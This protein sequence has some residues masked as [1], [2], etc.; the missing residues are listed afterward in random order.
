MRSHILNAVFRKSGACANSLLLFGAVLALL[1][2]AC[3]RRGRSITQ[4]KEGVLI[5]STGSFPLNENRL[6]LNVAV[7][8]EGIVR[9]ALKDR[10]GTTLIDSKKRTENPGAYQRWFLFWSNDSQLWF[11]SSDIGDFLWTKGTDGSYGCRWG[12]EDPKI[13][14]EMPQPFFDALPSSMKLKWS[15]FR[16]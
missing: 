15:K 1:T 4:F 8:S 14:G 12:N 13:V 2:S 6:T 5:R 10:N 16:Q 9:Y 7:D 3:G 11:W